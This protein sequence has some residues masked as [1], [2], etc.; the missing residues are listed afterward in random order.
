M[1]MIDVRCRKCGEKFG[2]RG[3]FAD[4]PPCPKCGA[5]VDPDEAA[6]NDA[7][8]DRS[9]EMASWDGPETKDGR[10]VAGVVQD[11]PDGT[12]VYVGR[13]HPRF[14]G[15]EGLWGNPFTAAPGA[16]KGA[17]VLVSSIE[18]AVDSYRRWLLK[19]HWLMLD[20]ER[21]NEIL[22]RLPELRG[23]RLA[24]WRHEGPCHAQVLA[25]LANRPRVEVPM[26]DT[27]RLRAV[28][29]LAVRERLHP[30]VPPG[31]R[32]AVKL[33]GNWGDG[34]ATKQEAVDAVIREGLRKLIHEDSRK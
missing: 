28:L 23:K 16:V 20:P 30:D 12:Y 10:A 25:D 13:K 18:E 19:E 31:I 3:R 8:L 33:D 15:Y 27:L 5:P 32:W 7:E 26:D 14:P 29:S 22:R 4:A 34:F 24:C 6:R 21:R 2:W 1:A 17:M 9:I 11:W